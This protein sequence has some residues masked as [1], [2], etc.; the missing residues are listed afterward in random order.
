MSV[1]DF[2]QLDDRATLD[3]ARDK[4]ATWTAGQPRLGLAARVDDLREQLAAADR[5][6]AD[7]VLAALAPMAAEAGQDDHDAAL[8][9]CWALL[10]GACRLAAHLRRGLGE[11]V[12]CAVAGQLWIE[13]RT[14]PFERLDR[15][16]ANILANTRVGVL[17]RFEAYS[18]MG[19]M[20]ASTVSVDPARLGTW[21]SAEQEGAGPPGQ[22]LLEVL[23]W[24]CQARV[25]SVADRGLLLALVHEADTVP[26]RAARELGG[27]AGNELS[28][29]VAAQW[30]VTSRTVRRRA[31]KSVA[32]LAAHASDYVDVSA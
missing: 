1:A 26:V 11:E 10:P 21:M 3:G 12:D 20:T 4:W 29:R 9:L 2:L 17:R 23:D 16:A 27:L 31:R 28:E 15:V 19:R 30:G 32:A 22:E 5:L 18:R 14:F 25:I 6:T 8:V 13:V 7:S 24:A